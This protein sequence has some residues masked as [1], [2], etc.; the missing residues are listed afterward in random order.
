M[1]VGKY[2][3]QFIPEDGNVKEIH[4]SRR[5]VV[6]LGIVSFLIIGTILYFSI[7][8]GKLAVDKIE[9][10]LL[11]NR[12]ANLENRGLE[13]E[14]LNNR[15]KKFYDVAD[16]LNKA[17]GLEISLE[18]F[19][20]AEEEKLT[21]KEFYKTD[22]IGSLKAEAERL[23]DFVPNILPTEEG[24]IS[25]RFSANHKAI[26][27]SLKEGTSIY[28]TMEGSVTFVGDREYLGLTLEIKNDEGFAIRFSHL[29]EILVKKGQEV[30]KNQLV[31][32]SGNSGRSDAPHLHYGLQMQGKWVDPINY[33]LIRR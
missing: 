23:Q 1:G 2:T 26:D 32:L 24:W 9:Y 4:L 12:V 17:L 7:N 27:I 19:Y 16:K 18:E 33:L 20:K 31:A 21:S 14:K 3:I 11:K 10:T 22:E 13:M 29:S 6:S 15:M 30:K 28:S 8:I 25:K 5:M